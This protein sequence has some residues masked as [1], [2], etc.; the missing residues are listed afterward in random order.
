MKGGSEF[1]T[2]L[3]RDTTSVDLT[4]VAIHCCSDSPIYTTLFVLLHS[5]S[6]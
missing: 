6:N 5:L 3:K 2:D 4:C 1:R